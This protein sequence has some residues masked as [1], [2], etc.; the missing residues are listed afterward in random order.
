[1]IL[2]DVDVNGGS[3]VAG[4]LVDLSLSFGRVGINL[5]GGLLILGRLLNL[6]LY[7]G[8][9]SFD[10]NFDIFEGSLDLLLPPLSSLLDIII[11]AQQR[12][13]YTVGDLRGFREVKVL[14]RTH[15]QLTPQ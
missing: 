10:L 1:L 11:D 8:S 15:P 14:S 7:F 2:V 5:D 9:I 6:G 13:L 3:A 12:L 4:R